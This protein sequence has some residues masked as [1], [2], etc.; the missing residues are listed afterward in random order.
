MYQ[1]LFSKSQATSVSYVQLSLHF[2]IFTICKVS[3]LFSVEIEHCNCEQ[4]KGSEWNARNKR[5]EQNERELTGRLKQ[6]RTNISPASTIL[7]NTITYNNIHARKSLD[8]YWL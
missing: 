2:E 4:V 7:E 8:S 3:T 1:K 6:I 5:D